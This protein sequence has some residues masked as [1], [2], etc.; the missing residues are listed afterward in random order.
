[1]YQIM[2]GKESPGINDIGISQLVV[3]SVYFVL[4]RPTLEL[5][6]S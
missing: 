5:V 4:A 6:V 2:V 3:A 1:M